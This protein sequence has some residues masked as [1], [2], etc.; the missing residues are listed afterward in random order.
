MIESQETPKIPD[1]P[2][3]EIN[4]SY[5]DE[6]PQR[7]EIVDQEGKNLGEIDIRAI[8][9]TGRYSPYDGK[10]QKA[11]GFRGLFWTKRY[12]YSPEGDHRT[13]YTYYKIGLNGEI[14]ITHHQTNTDGKTRIVYDETIYP[15]SLLSEDFSPVNIF[16]GIEPSEENP[17]ESVLN[18]LEVYTPRGR[19]VSGRGVSPEEKSTEK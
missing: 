4:L 5:N 13:Y 17:Q 12:E 7:I 9:L 10:K 8:R 19:L 11:T 6:K 18:F 15:S 16:L 2:V 14:K 3:R 1:K